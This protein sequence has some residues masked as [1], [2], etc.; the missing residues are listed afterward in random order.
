MC[1][2]A[3]L[4]AYEQYL[5]LPEV[6]RTTSS[7]ADMWEAKA[8]IR[9]ALKPFEDPDRLKSIGDTLST[10]IQCL[11]HGMPRFTDGAEGSLTVPLYALLSD[12]AKS[13]QAIFDL[14]FKEEL[15]EAD[16]FDTVRKQLW[17]NLCA[18]SRIDPERPEKSRGRALLPKK[19]DKPVSE[20]FSLYFAHTPFL[21]FLFSP[22]PFSIP[23]AA[24]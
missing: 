18:I 3:A 15:S 12:P 4:L 5:H 19:V 9:K 11:V 16:I 6:D 2:C 7:L 14:I 23:F 13:I 22:I 10:F 24:L 8:A 1:L 17:Y 20:L 21:D